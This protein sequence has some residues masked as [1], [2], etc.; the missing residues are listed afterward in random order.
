[1]D[2]LPPKKREKGFAT[3]RRYYLYP[4]VVETGAAGSAEEAE[5]VTGVTGVD[6]ACPVCCSRFGV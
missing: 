2:D 5:V 6:V 1:M 3:C 4:L